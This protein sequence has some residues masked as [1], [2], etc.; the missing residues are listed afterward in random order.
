MPVIPE[1]FRLEDEDIAS[2]SY[3]FAKTIE[4]TGF[5]VV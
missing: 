2:F 4:Q 3:Q 1:S 5:E